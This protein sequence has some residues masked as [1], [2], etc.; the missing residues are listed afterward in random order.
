MSGLARRLAER[1]LSAAARMLPPHLSTWS[2]AMAHELI[3][4][5]DDRS[6]LLFSAGC[7][8][9][10]VTLSVAER[11]RS[12]FAAARAR[13]FPQPSAWSF[14]IMN[15]N[16]AQPRL[17]GLICGSAAVAIGIAYMQATGAP[18]RY[19]LVNLAAL[20]LGATAWLALGRVA[21][22][23]LAGA[24][25]AVLA[26]SVPLLLTAW[27]GTA[28]DGVSRWVSVGPLNLQVSFILVPVAIVIY[29]RRPDRIGT[30]GMIA[31][32]LALAVQ[33]DRAMAAV[34][35]VALTAVALE[36]RGR[37]P[38]LAA[39]VSVLAFGRTLL[40]P[41]TLSAA[42]HVDRV[43]YAAFEV[44][45]LAGAAVLAGI[46][47]LIVPAVAGLSKGEG[48]RAVLLAFGACWSAVAA[49]AALGNYP[50]P[51]VGYG[52]SAVL[53]YLLSVSLLPGGA[54]EGRGSAIESPQ[55]AGRDLDPGRPELRAASPA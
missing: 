16:W 9:A 40:A 4:I 31:A 53:G 33:P 1:M 12:A 43:L 24:G 37:L 55:A 23:S 18:S 17:L 45:P 13:L 3:E 47:A 26:S 32:A 49:A 14:P 8:R 54:R 34:L 39:A 27:F 25:A 50:T 21:R 19:L 15:R 6:A 36:T 29:A 7:L 5:D 2:R 10:A 20:V 48:D 46:A 41:D 44:H 52:G 11:L 38:A 42:P 35:A 28:V 30:A 22:S 51:L